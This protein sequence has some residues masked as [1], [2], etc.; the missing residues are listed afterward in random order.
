MA[1]VNPST[2]GGFELIEHPAD[3]GLRFWGPTLGEAYIQAAQGLRSMLA[4]EGEVRISRQVPLDISGQDRLEVLFNWLNEILFRFD[5]EQLVL[6]SFELLAVSEQAISAVG[7]G[8][9]YD[10]G[11]HETPYYVKAITYHQMALEP[12][13]DGW[14]GQV[15]VDI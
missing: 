11:R 15:Y 1:R 9:P 14:H 3:I 12:E 6:G 5:A 4:G 2:T 10:P 7:H 8:E 13:R